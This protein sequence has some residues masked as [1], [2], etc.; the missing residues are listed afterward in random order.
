M[1]KKSLLAGHSFC[2]AGG[3][4]V[5]GYR[6]TGVEN[7]FKRC[8]LDTHFLSLLLGGMVVEQL[9]LYTEG[10]HQPQQMAGNDTV[11]N[12]T[13]GLIQQTLR[14]PGLGLLQLVVPQ[15]VL[16]QAANLIQVTSPN[17]ASLAEFSSVIKVSVL[18]SFTMEIKFFM[19]IIT[20]VLFGP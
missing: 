11:A 10:L 20:S 18:S 17:A 3:D 8:L 14:M 12:D 6:L 4:F 15:V 19:C 5:Q 9:D 16:S 13:D 1:W 2:P 7:L